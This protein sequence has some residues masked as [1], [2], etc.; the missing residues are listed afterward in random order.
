M[1][2][3]GFTHWPPASRLSM[4][5]ATFR[6]LFVAALAFVTYGTL[7]PDPGDVAGMSLADFIASRILGEPA[8]ADKVGHFMAYATLSG[9]MVMGRAAPAGSITLGA[10][11]LAVYGFGLEGLQG[12]FPDRQSDWRDG[13]ANAAGV[14]FA[15]PPG[16]LVRSALAGALTSADR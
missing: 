16:M 3:G 6:A 5:D 1:A 4:L 9:L 15:L 10:T 8:L 13:L 11:A 12:F 2:P 7:N 14:A